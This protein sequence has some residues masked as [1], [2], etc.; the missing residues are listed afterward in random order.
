M[1]EQKNNSASNSG[2]VKKYFP[3]VLPALLTLVLMFFFKHNKEEIGKIL[4]KGKNNLLSLYANNLKPLLVSTPITEEDV[5]NFALYQCLL[6]DKNKSK[7]LV[8]NYDESNNQ[9]Y[10]IRTASFNPSTKNYETFV[11]YLGLD[12]LQKEEADS[13]L[14][15]YKKE[16][17]TSVFVS[18]KNTFAV[19]SNISQL[20]Q[21]VL[22][23]LV[24]FTQKINPEK[25]EE[26]FHKSFTRNDNA[27]I[28]GLISSA[29]QN[30]RDEFLLF[31]PD[32]VAKTHAEWNRQKF[33]KQL[34]EAEK[35]KKT[36][37]QKAEEF[38]FKLGLAPLSEEYGKNMLPDYKFTVDS[39]MYK[40]VVSLDA[41][42]MSQKLG[43]SIRIKLNEVA[44]NL[45]K[46]SVELNK[47]KLKHG[48]SIKIPV[49]QVVRNGKQFEIEIVNPYEIID[50]TFEALSNANAKTWEEYEKIDSLGNMHDKKM[51]DSIKIKMREHVRKIKDEIKKSRRNV[52]PDT[53][54]TLRYMQ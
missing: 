30:N 42:H 53:S 39:N 34:E 19:N 24:T 22:A 6:L 17:Y 37:L 49:P 21:A 25:A 43:D 54:G 14:N 31:T 15:L 47:Q 16:I 7:I 23:D 45:K 26:I 52:K 13:I 40:V 32:T 3:Y 29:R 51:N 18:D 2:F 28:A 33:Y 20:Q 48:S 36:A 9:V 12:K 5:F 44:A 8:V 4:E 27:K 10:E 46:M 35:S 1:D 50:K 11:K 41:K 38:D